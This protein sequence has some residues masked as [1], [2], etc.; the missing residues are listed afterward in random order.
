[1]RKLTV[2]VVITVSVMVLLVI[3]AFFYVDLSGHRGFV[4]E[5]LVGEKLSGTLKIDRYVTEDKLVY[6]SVGEYPETLDY[7]L[8]SEKLF[9]RKKT[10]ALLKFIEEASGIK[11]QK[12]LTM[13]AGE[14]GKFDFLFIEHPRFSI[15]K[16]V[17]EG[18]D[19]MVFSPYDPVLCMAIMDKYNFW[20]KGV[21]FFKV[22]VPV[23]EA[24]PPLIG[25]L[26]V[27]YLED[28]FILVMG[29]KVEAESYS[30]RSGTLPEVKV[31]LSKYGHRLIKMDVGQKNI[32]YT[33][34][35]T[36]EDP[37]KRLKL[38]TE[39]LTALFTRKGLEES[40]QKQEEEASPG[41][42]SAEDEKLK[43]EK[44]AE[45]DADEGREEVFFE[46]TGLI[47]SGRLWKPK[48]EGVSPAVL[49][50]PSDSTI[51]KGV[52][53]LIEHLA[54][55]LSESGFTVLEFDLPGQGKSQ[56]SFAG[57]DD[58][59][60]LKHIISAA[61]YLE[62]LPSSDKNS[63]NFIGYG[64]AGYFAVNA[65]TRVPSVNS[66]IL[67]DMPLWSG[68]ADIPRKNSKKDLKEI[69][70][71]KGFGP[72]NEEYSESAAKAIVEQNKDIILSSDDFSF[73]LGTKI[74]DKE[75][76]EF[77]TRDYYGSIVSFDRPLLFIHRKE[78]TNFAPQSVNDI[79]K[80]FK[81]KGVQVEFVTFRSTGQY[82]QD[83]AI[84]NASGFSVNNNML[85]AIK[86]WLK[87]S[88]MRKQEPA[89]EAVEEVAA[90]GGLN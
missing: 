77:L 70:A 44:P 26:E 31:Y 79:K 56:G 24:V 58:E 88:G 7:P 66:C 82:M 45:P 21:Q 40:D 5:L 35:S 27:K 90:S 63:I 32:Q 69:F 62:E 42:R 65:A 29:R 89:E 55:D 53:L 13:I 23:G 20:K 2:L 68:K 8:V 6:K 51:K 47:L 43:G 74:P 72:L 37:G 22:M 16:Q 34:V 57:L 19:V 61:A 87:E 38:L 4:F 41:E 83:I 85:E 12:R 86:K 80:L 67:L 25:D 39:K 75:Y 59:K 1:M 10:L 48:A 46:S 84:M 3:L 17:S 33:M 81:D 50:V 30:F 49:I 73:F 60:K 15:L 36:I 18:K 9:L 71:L 52:A 28:E 11:G 64:D 54:G 78:G 14:S 76:R